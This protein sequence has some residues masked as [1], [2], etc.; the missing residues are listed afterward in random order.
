MADEEAAQQPATPAA[1]SE[2]TPVVR[3]GAAVSAS[4]GHAVVVARQPQPMGVGL[5]K[6]PR[7]A[8]IITSFW[9]GMGAML[10]GI[11]STIVYMLWPRGVTGFGS[12]VFVGNVDLFPA[13]VPVKNTEAKAWI[14]K[15]DATQAGRNGG[16]EGAILA[17][18]QK[19]PHLGCTVPWRPDY[20]REDPR[21][22]ETYA[23]WFLCPCHGSTYSPAGVRVFGPAPRSMD[24]FAVS[25]SN[26]GI[27]VNT[28]D[29]TPGNT[30][31][32]TRGV[33]PG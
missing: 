26:G 30:E 25:I 10:A 23:G 21:S 22:G 32:A 9:V 1:K 15:L 16:Q 7:R 3:S 2:R 19:C 12:T 13:G 4:G 27:T 5:P 11:A 33:L 20:T 24:T 29:I 6:I 28:G 17:L 14:V 8:M 18:W 31:N